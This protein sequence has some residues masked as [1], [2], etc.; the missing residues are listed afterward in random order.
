MRKFKLFWNVGKEVQWLNEMA[1]KGWQLQSFRYGV[2]TFKFEDAT[3]YQYQ[4]EYIDFLKT[5]VEREEYLNFLQQAGVELVY[6]TSMYCYFRKVNDGKAFELHTSTESKLNQYKSHVKLSKR[7]LIPA[8]LVSGAVQFIP[9][10][11]HIADFFKGVFVGISTGIAIL[12][13][14]VMLLMLKLKREN[15]LFEI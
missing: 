10:T 5:K 8:L 2:Y 12:T 9:V 6:K 4:T 3:N 7:V 1:E 14:I 15:K 13:I 11:G